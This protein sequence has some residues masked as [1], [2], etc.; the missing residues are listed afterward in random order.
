MF[1]VSLGLAGV[2]A[3]GAA[4]AA[5]GVR[6][7]PAGL[8]PP[9]A[10]GPALCVGACLSPEQGKAVLDAALARFPDRAAWSAYAAHVRER[11]QQGVGLAPW[12]QRTPLNA[13]IHSRRDYDG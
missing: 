8:P 5:P 6:W 2:L 9:P 3:V 11:I 1:R 7:V 13:V 4:L 12:P 10:Q